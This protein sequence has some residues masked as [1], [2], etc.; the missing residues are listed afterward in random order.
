M[1]TIMRTT[2]FPLPLIAAALSVGCFGL[3]AAPS[4]AQTKA[5]TQKQA[6]TQAD[7]ITNRVVDKVWAETDEYWHHGD[8]NRIVALI[9][10]IVEADP[11]FYEA[12]GDGA[13]LI[14]SM[15]DT[16]NADEF[17]EYGISRA[18]QK[19]VL[20][21]EFGYH[22]FNTKRYAAALPYLQKAVTYPKG[23]G[24][25]PW[26]T[27]AHCYDKLGQ[28][29]KCLETWEYVVRTYPDDAVA[30]VRLRDIRARVASGA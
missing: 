29:Q 7:G 5:E 21:Y 1:K 2:S 15:G 23:A 4:N 6:V 18:P 17:L 27:L 16:K 20:Q 12:Y 24:W 22:L 26:H 11:T 25:P 10:V 3:C 28:K 13:W 30:K 8:Y 14:W 9:R 19:W